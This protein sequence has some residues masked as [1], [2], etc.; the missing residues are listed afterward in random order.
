MENLATPPLYSMASLTADL[1]RIGVRAGMQLIVHSSFKAIGKVVGGPT[2]VILALEAVVGETGTLLMPTFTEKLC[3]PAEEENYYPVEEQEFARQHLPG[4]HSDLTPVDR[5]IGIIP[6]IFRKQHGSLRSSHPHLSF[7]ARGACAQ[8]LIDDHAFDYALGEGSP[9][10]KLYR[11]GGSI[12]LL[13]APKNSNTSLHLAEYRQNEARK[14]TRHWRAPVMVD[15]IRQWV[16]YRDIEN[17]CDDFAAI[18]DDFIESSGCCRQGKIGGAESF[19]F[20]QRHI[21]DFAVQWMEK[22]R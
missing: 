7:A 13:G 18:L 2:A 3:D 9:L 1:E 20:P 16:E 6:E 15:G 10:G 11:L 14:K 12:L 8:A 19:F 4:Y 22:H 21:V 5:W 17:N